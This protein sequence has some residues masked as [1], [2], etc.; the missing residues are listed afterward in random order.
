MIGTDLQIHITHTGYHNLMLPRSEDGAEIY[1]L[2]EQAQAAN[3]PKP[4]LYPIT[5]IPLKVLI[6]FHV[7]LCWK[8]YNISCY[9]QLFHIHHSV[10]NTLNV[11]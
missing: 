5:A 3:K 11:I 9:I 4:S 2:S 1:T 6:V 7:C 10:L 8:L